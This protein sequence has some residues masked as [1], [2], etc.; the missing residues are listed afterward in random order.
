VAT[1]SLAA[2]GGEMLGAVISRELGFQPS[3][4]AAVRVAQQGGLR[5]VVERDGE[6]DQTPLGEDALRRPLAEVAPQ[7]G[8]YL[9]VGRKVARITE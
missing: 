8:A 1:V 3:F 7:P 2:S 9:K 6:Q 4:K 5:L